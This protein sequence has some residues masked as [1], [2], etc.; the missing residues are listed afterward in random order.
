MGVKATCLVRMSK[1][2]LA[3]ADGTRIFE[4]S[5]RPDGGRVSI[6]ARSSHGVV[7]GACHNFGTHRS[8]HRGSQRDAHRALG[9]H[10]N[11]VHHHLCA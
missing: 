1:A 4:V 8:G 2:S 9:L 10:F 11:F 6:R 5:G 7:R 3:R